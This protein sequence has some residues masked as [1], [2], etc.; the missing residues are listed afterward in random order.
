[1]SSTTYLITPQLRKV[2]TPVYG[3][4]RPVSLDHI[5]YDTWSIEYAATPADYHYPM[6]APIAKTVRYDFNKGDAHTL[7]GTY[8]YNVTK[9]I[10]YKA[11]A[12]VATY[13]YRNASCTHKVIIEDRFPPCN[14]RFR[15]SPTSSPTS[16][17]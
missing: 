12:E 2:G 5:D 15:P 6:D 4:I 14:G 3:Q 11:G 17:M 16:K 9:L 10:L 13:L 7:E 1:M 8:Y